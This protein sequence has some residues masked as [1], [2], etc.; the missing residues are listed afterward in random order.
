MGWLV[1]TLNILLQ[2]FVADEL[3]H[4][5]F[6]DSTIFNC[7]TNITMVLTILVVVS[8]VNW[9]FNVW[10]DSVDP[11]VLGLKVDHGHAS[12]ERRIING[13]NPTIEFFMC[14]RPLST[15]ETYQTEKSD[16]I[17]KFLN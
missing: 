10:G 2:L 3:L 17:M 9:G 12:S 16:V 7:V 11:L 6:Q 15:Y 4:F 1:G 13:R 5:K 14:M 8:L